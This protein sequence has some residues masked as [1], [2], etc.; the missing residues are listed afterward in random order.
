MSRSMSAR[1]RI[2]VHGG[3]PPLALEFH[4]RGSAVY[5]RLTDQAVTR[6]VEIKDGALADY[7]TDDALV[8]LELLHFDDPQVIETLHRMQA[9]FADE[10]PQLRSVEATS[11]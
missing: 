8:G 6:T 4:R 9:R 2:A 3:Q 10:A 7:D 1:V 11:I 5:L